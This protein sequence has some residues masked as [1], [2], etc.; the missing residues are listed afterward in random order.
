MA[1]HL[2]RDRLTQISDLFW[3]SQ[4]HFNQTEKPNLNINL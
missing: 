2:I 4:L 1:G 3:T